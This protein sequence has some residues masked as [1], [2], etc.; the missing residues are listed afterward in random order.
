MTSPFCRLNGDLNRLYPPQSLSL[1]VTSSPSCASVASSAYFAMAVPLAWETGVTEESAV[2]CVGA[3]G[4]WSKSKVSAAFVE[5]S[6]GW[7]ECAVDAAGKAS[8]AV[9]SGGTISRFFLR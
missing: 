9:E 6:T 4:R 7:N 3:S 8:K 5:V 2:G 1:A